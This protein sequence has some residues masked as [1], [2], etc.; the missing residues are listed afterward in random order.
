MSP[1]P[2]GKASRNLDLLSWPDN[3]DASLQIRTP[4]R[5]SATNDSKGFA[6]ASDESYREYSSA[7]RPGIRT[8]Q[9]AGGACTYAFGEQLS[10]EEAEALLKRRPGSES[11]MKEMSGNKIF[12][13]EPGAV[14]AAPERTGVKLFQAITF[15]DND[16]TSP[17][18]ATT[19]AELAKQKELSG[20]Q[21]IPDDDAQHKRLQSNAKVKE[22]VGSNIFAP[23]DK[24]PQNGSTPVKKIKEPTIPVDDAPG[25]MSPGERKRS[26]TQKTAELCGN[27]IFKNDPLKTPSDSKHLSSAKLREM[28]GN[29]IF[30][31]DKP[32]PRDCLGGVRKPPGGEST[33]ALV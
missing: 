2:P 28:S 26:L 6:S 25:L 5:V 12:C 13:D 10:S 22:L 32:V 7:G 20:S 29:D 16:N 9:P 8:H 11:K 27:D 17:R 15:G 14:P 30:A 4:V 21:A 1:P 23:E 31:D 18:K 19:Q 24:L 33:I 3:P